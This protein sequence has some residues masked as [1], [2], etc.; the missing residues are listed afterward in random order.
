MFANICVVVDDRRAHPADTKD[1][2]NIML[3]GKDPKTGQGLSNDNI[4]RNVRVPKDTT[5]DVC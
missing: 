4:I 1:L 2:L 3:H 5:F